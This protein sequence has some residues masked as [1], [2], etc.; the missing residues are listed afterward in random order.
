[1]ATCHRRLQDT[2]DVLVYAAWQIYGDLDCRD[3]DEY[4]TLFLRQETDKLA[5][6]RDFKRQLRKYAANRKLK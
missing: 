5:Y 2:L 1:M 4:N 3:F 6:D